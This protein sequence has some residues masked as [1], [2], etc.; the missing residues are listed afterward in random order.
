MWL[1]TIA[2]RIEQAKA[3]DPAVE[4]VAKAYNAALP[5]GPVKDALHGTWLG[6]QLHP[7]L[8]AGPIGLWSS[9]V[10]LS[11]MPC[12]ITKTLTV[13]TAASCRPTRPHRH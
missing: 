1:S 5:R 4:A 10:L 3:L 2:G 9:A 11:V 6:H 7:M 8:I 13:A 12:S